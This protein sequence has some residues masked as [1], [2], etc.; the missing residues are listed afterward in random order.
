MSG[1]DDF[2]AKSESRT[3]RPLNTVMRRKGSLTIPAE[4]RRAARL[5]EGDVVEVEMTA[6]GILLR[7]KKLIDATQ[8]WFW[9]P[10]W[11]AREREADAADAAGD[12]ER[13]DSDEAFLAALDARMKPLDA[14]A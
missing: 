1:S 8:A 13:F 6:D 3:L 2:R 10:S 12:F 7:P 14:D 5:A 11:Q 4:I 9:E